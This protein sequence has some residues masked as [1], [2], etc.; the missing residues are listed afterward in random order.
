LIT[1]LGAGAPIILEIHGSKFWRGKA[2]SAVA[3]AGLRKAVR[4]WKTI[5]PKA[6]THPTHEVRRS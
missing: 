3:A 4:A 1:A 5:S 6:E 2:W